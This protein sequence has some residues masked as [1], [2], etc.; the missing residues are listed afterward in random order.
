M[1]MFNDINIDK[2]GNEI[3]LILTPS[4]IQENS[5]KFHGKTRGRSWDP[6]KKI[7]VFVDAITNQKEDETLLLPE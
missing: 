7:H 6:E 5:S 3:T 1:S 4:I 2:E